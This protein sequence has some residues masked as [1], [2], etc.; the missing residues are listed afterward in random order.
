M[1]LSDTGGA[2][3]A[4][5]DMALAMA[6]AIAAAPT[7]AAGW[8]G[9]GAWGDGAADLDA[10]PRRDVATARRALSAAKRRMAA[11]AMQGWRPKTALR[12][13]RDGVMLISGIREEG[14][15]WIFYLTAASFFPI[16]SSGFCVLGK[17]ET[18]RSRLNFAWPKRQGAIYIC[19]SQARKDLFL[20]KKYCT[21]DSFVRRSRFLIINLYGDIIN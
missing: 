17:K 5:V 18:R 21:K 6:A 20:G 14:Q 11:A 3:T 4:A 9:A 16:C 2:P 10:A 15:V 1:V 19:F 12:R 8:R 7:G 13:G